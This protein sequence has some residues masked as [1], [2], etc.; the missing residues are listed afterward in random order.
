MLLIPVI[1]LC[2]PN[3]S[4]TASFCL[5]L[6]SFQN[7]RVSW[8]KTVWTVLMRKNWKKKNSLNLLSWWLENLA[9]FL[10]ITVYGFMWCC[11]TQTWVSRQM[12]AHSGVKKETGSKYR[13]DMVMMGGSSSRWWAY[14]RTSTKVNQQSKG[15]REKDNRDSHSAAAAF[16][17]YLPLELNVTTNTHLGLGGTG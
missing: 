7:G 3:L 15:V 14:G 16:A 1:L 9:F 10:R 4:P 6:E 12:Q 2:L 8:E 17:I 11:R 5:L 13:I